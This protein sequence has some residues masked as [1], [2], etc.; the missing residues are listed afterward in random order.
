[1]ELED[2]GDE[3]GCRHEKCG[4][5]VLSKLVN[6]SCCKTCSKLCLLGVSRGSL[7]HAV[8]KRWSL[9]NLFIDCKSRKIQRGE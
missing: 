2:W 6:E 7:K 8:R 9:S 1:M 4:L 5:R 3:I